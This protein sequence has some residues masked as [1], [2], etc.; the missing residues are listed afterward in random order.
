MVT[1]IVTPA[2]APARLVSLVTLT[3]GANGSL[4]HPIAPTGV[5]VE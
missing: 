3:P 1:S 2:G 5:V 4:S